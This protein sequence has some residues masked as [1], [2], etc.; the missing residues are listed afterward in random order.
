MQ[1]EWFS[2]FLCLDHDVGPWIGLGCR[3]IL[4]RCDNS[5]LLFP[6]FATCFEAWWYCSI[7]LIVANGKMDLL[8]CLH[9]CIFISIILFHIANCCGFC[10]PV[11][12]ASRWLG[13]HA[14]DSGCSWWWLNGQMQVLQFIWWLMTIWV[15]IAVSCMPWFMWSWFCIRI[16]GFMACFACVIATLVKAYWSG[17][18]W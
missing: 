16:Y 7:V 12:L 8:G 6:Y 1:V 18:G 3:A 9:S 15:W 17:I 13:I 2:N 10:C 11:L 4:V 14:A 5:Y